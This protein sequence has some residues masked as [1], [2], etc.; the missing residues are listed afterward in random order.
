MLTR[1]PRG[2]SRR[3]RIKRARGAELSVHWIAKSE[4]VVPAI[5]AAKA[6]D[7]W[8]LNVLSSPLLVANRQAIIER[9]AQLRLPAMYQWPEM[10]EE[11]GLMAY[12]PRLIQIF[13]ELGRRQ[14]IKL[15]RGVRP[16]DLP[17]EQPTQFDL[18]INLKTAKALGLTKI[19]RASCR[20]GGEMTKGN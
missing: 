18:V 6:S 11:G 1:T 14:L 19:G 15:F 9:T 8:A 12:G 3:C 16:E 4:E 10:A 7:A 2:I 17:V 5:D 13:R 20:E